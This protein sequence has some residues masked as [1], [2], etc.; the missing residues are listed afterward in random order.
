MAVSIA[1]I[2]VLSLIADWIF[3]RFRIPGLIGMLLVG[4]LFGPYVLG[5]L[6]PD[7]LAIGPDLRLIA[8][9]VILLRAGF[10]LS[11]RILHRVGGKALLLSF[12][13]AVIEGA[14]ITVLG[15]RLLGLS[16]MES[17]ILGSVLAAVSPAVVVPMMIRFMQER[18]GAEKG[19]PTMI[20][21]AASVDDVFVIV[22]YSVLTGLYT[23][24]QVNIAWKLASIPLSIILGVAV[25]LAA[26][27]VLY[28]LFERFDPRATKR[29]L[30]VIAVSVL[31][32]RV[33][34]A[35]EAWVPFAALVSAMAIGF[36]ILE[37]REHMAH[38]ISAKLG[39][40]WVFAEIILFSMV[41]AQVNLAVAWKAGLAGA[42][43]IGL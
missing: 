21:A 30:V 16:T 42:A 39:K 34:H 41:G 5:Y 2:I 10:E 20:L 19:I 12:I 29:V 3:R 27:L 7:L 1:E 22:V 32:V 4:V 13:P 33:E 28:R 40:I 6:D 11:R 38:E 37:K 35:V 26:G 36:V 14:A 9:I 15:P 43:L 31:L 17:A 23:G 18:K 24:Q 25:G 8:L